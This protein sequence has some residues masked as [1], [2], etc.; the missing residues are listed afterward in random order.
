MTDKTF[1]EIMV[2]EAARRGVSVMV[3]MKV[4]LSRIEGVS[5]VSETDDLQSVVSPR[6]KAHQIRN[7][8]FIGP[9]VKEKKA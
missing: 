7:N 9:G 4:D 6:C 5:M 3:N 2:E 8:L 1:L